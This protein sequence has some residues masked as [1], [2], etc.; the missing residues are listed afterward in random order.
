MYAQDPGFR[1]ACSFGVVPFPYISSVPDTS[2]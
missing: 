1:K 2:K